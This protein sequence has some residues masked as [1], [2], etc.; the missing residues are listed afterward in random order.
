MSNAD[1]HL[2]WIGE[3]VGRFACPVGYS[4]HTTELISG[5]M[6]VGAGACV[7]EKHLTYDRSA[8][9]PDHAASADAAMFERYVAMIRTAQ[10]L[11]GR[12][13]RRVLAAEEDVRR[14]SRQSVVVLRRLNP[15]DVLRRDD[16]T[17]QRPGTGIPAADLERVLGRTIARPVSAGEVLQWDMLLALSDAA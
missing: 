7:I 6:A 15:G 1:A 17:I 5:V 4:D 12:R 16:V 9:G 10:E 13:G 11:R 14:L 2:A 3:L 8:E